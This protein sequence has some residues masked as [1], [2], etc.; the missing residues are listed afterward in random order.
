MPD[1]T[2]RRLTVW[3]RRFHCIKVDYADRALARAILEDHITQDDALLISAFIAERKITSNLIILRRFIKPYRENT[4]PD[5]YRGIDKLNSALSA[6]GIPFS[7]NSRVDI[8]H[9]CK[10][11]FLW[12]IENEE[13]SISEKKIRAIKLPRKIST[14]KASDLLTN[15][16]L[17]ALLTA[18][19][20]SRDRALLITL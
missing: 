3:Q 16:E 18:C 12:L 2:P 20:T 13:I 1:H 4:V 10:Q 5:I 8:I 19:M 17:Q 6:R 9:I 15:D 7:Q 14:K 11:F